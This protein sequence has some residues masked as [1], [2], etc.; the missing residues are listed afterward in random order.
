MY[1]ST[2]TPQIGLLCRPQSLRNT[3]GNDHILVWQRRTLNDLECAIQF[4]LFLPIRITLSWEIRHVKNHVRTAIPLHIILL[5]KGFMSLSA[6]LLADAVSANVSS[7][8]N[9]EHREFSTCRMLPCHSE[10]EIFFWGWQQR[11]GRAHWRDLFLGNLSR[12]RDVQFS[13]SP[14]FDINIFLRLLELSRNYGPWIRVAHLLAGYPRKWS[15]HCD[16][17]EPQTET[18]STPYIY[19]MLCAI[20]LLHLWMP[21]WESPTLYRNCFRHPE[22]RY[23]FQL[24]YEQRKSCT[25]ITVW[26]CAC[27]KFSVRRIAHRSSR[28]RG[29][30]TLFGWEKHAVYVFRRDK[31]PT[32][33]VEFESSS[34]PAKFEFL[35]R[36]RPIGETHPQQSH[37]VTRVHF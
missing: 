7:H 1:S 29:H 20:M 10:R 4:S 25:H 32:V 5:P 9:Q 23:C 35:P 8:W 33:P 24:G 18:Y 30:S 12:F 14:L 27:N 3:T 28:S 6:A 15:V 37:R 34:E 21:M 13:A 16:S 11:V 17:S 26:K 19:Y 2:S 31:S 36:I 22:Q